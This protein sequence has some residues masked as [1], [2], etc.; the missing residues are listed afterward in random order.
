MKIETYQWKDYGKEFLLLA[1]V[2]FPLHFA[3]ENAQCSIFF[4]HGEQNPG[5]MSMVRA[6]LG[7]VVMTW[8]D[9]GFVAALVG[10]RNWLSKPWKISHWS[11]SILM[12]LVMS[13]AMELYG[14]GQG[15]WQYTSAAPLIPGTSISLIPVLQLIILIPASFWIAGQIIFRSKRTRMH[16][17]SGSGN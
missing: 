8:I 16:S 7:D 14:M 17:V 11:A 2:S 10:D 6:T 5:I 1:L 9:F 12:A 3:W 15:H 4:I 13:I